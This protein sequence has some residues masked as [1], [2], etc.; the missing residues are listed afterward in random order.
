MEKTTK[1][2]NKD[3]EKNIKTA[4]PKQNYR[5]MLQ[6]YYNKLLIENNSRRKALSL[7]QSAEVFLTE[8]RQLVRKDRR[9][10]LRIA[11]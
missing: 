7:N 3:S 10:A 4:Q 9:N 5:V 8:L 1:R 6:D 11:A 2:S